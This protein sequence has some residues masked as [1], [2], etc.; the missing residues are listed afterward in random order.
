[1]LCFVWLQWQGNVKVGK[2]AVRSYVLM[3]MK[4]FPRFVC[5]KSH[6]NVTRPQFVKNRRMVS[7][8][9]PSRMNSKSVWPATVNWFRCNDS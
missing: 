1:M 8:A 7:V 4:I 6:S 2:G 3:R 9:G 5:G